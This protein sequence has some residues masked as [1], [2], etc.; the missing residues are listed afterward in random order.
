[1][2]R[3]L[4]VDTSLPFFAYGIFKP[5]QLCFYRISEF[6]EESIEGTVDG[7]LKER[8]GIPLLVLAKDC[9]SIYGDLIRF[10]NEEGCEAYSR[11]MDIEPEE[12]YRWE[13][14]I[15]NGSI[16]A[17]V[18]IG[19]RAERGS[20]ELEHVNEWDGKNDPYF[21]QGL[22]VVDEILRENSNFDWDFKSLL[23]LQMAY[24]LLWTAIERYASLKYHLGKQVTH[25]VY[26]IAN[27][28][29]FANALKKVVSDKREVF[30]TVKLNK[31]TLDPNNPKKSLEYYYQVRSNSIHRGKTVVKDFDTVKKS[32]EELLEIF[33]IMLQ[34][35]FGGY[36]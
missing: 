14:T 11:I 8:D 7:Y 15:V 21:K 29:S 9:G 34:N 36:R 16:Y 22:E 10:K 12:V 28:E 27:E 4:P 17:N 20:T 31:V 18:L 24:A 3:Q 5:G 26:Q 25:K 1:M 33:R 23:R 6:A 19:K 13:R 32:L 35:S 30:D 2:K